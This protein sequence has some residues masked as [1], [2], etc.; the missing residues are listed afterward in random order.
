MNMHKSGLGMLRCALRSTLLWKCD[1]SIMKQVP[2]CYNI[3]SLA[4]TQLGS[5]KNKALASKSIRYYSHSAPDAA[6]ESTAA[7]ETT[8]VQQNEAEK[9][10]LL[11]YLA[12][13]KSPTEVLDELNRYSISVNEIGK[14]F[15][16]MWECIEEMNSEQKQMKFKLIIEHPEFSALCE[17]LMIEAG[18][19]KHHA[20]GRTLY[21]AVNLGVSQDSRVVQTLLRVAQEHLNQFDLNS[22]C[23]L[24]RVLHDMKSRNALALREA[25]WLLLKDHIYETSNVATLTKLMNVVG[26]DSPLKLK[27]QLAQHGKHRPEPHTSVGHL[28]QEIGRCCHKMKYRN[29]TLFSSISKHMALTIDMCT[30]QQVLKILQ[31]FEKLI[32]RPVELLDVFAERIIQEPEYL[33]VNELLTVLRVFSMANHDLKDKK[34]EFLSSLMPVIE[35]HL[36]KMSPGPL[37]SLAFY[38]S[39]MQHFPPKPLEILLQPRTVECLMQS[40]QNGPGYS[41]SEESHLNMNMHKSGLGM[42]RC[43]LRSTLLWKCDISIMKQV[44]LCYNIK[45][46]ASTQLGSDKN[47]ALASK[48][49]RYYSHSAP[50]AAKE[51]TAATETT[52]VQQ[53]E[54]EKNALLVYLAGCKSPT[55][56]LDELNR[57]SISVNEIG[58]IFFRMWE[59]IEEMNSEQ[60]QIKFKLIIEHPEFSALCERLMI[61]AGAMKHHA[62]GRTLYAAVNLGVSQDSRVVQTLLRV[63]QEHLNQF[64]LNSLC[65]LSRALHDMKS[66]NALALREAIWLLLKDHIYETSNVATLTKLMNVV[67]K[68]SPLKLKKQLASKVFSLSSEFTSVDNFYIFSSMANIDVKHTHLLDTCSKKLAENIHDYSFTQLL[69]VL[70]CCYQMKYRNYT[71]F[72]SISKHM[73]LTIDMC[74]DQQ[75]LKILQAFEKLIFRPVELLDVFAERIIQEPE[76]LSVNELLTVLRVFSMANHDLKDKKTE[77]LSSLM[78][79]IELHLPKMSPGPLLSLTFYLSLMQHFPPKPLEILLQPRTVECLMQSSQDGPEKNS[80]M[81]YALNLSLRLENPPLP[82]S[83]SSLTK[84]NLPSLDINHRVDQEIR[85]LIREIVGRDAV[86]EAVVEQGFY[87]IDFVIS[88]PVQEETPGLQTEGAGSSQCAQRIALITVRENGLCYGTNHYRGNVVRK[89]RHLEKLGYKT[90]LV[91]YNYF[92][93]MPEAEKIE[94]LRSI[95]QPQM[96][97]EIIGE[98]KTE[99]IS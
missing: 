37:L 97:K 67:G 66:R 70:R 81:L 86:Q 13:C 34:T 31:A 9:N 8:E 48:S 49:I 5:D 55:E 90:V 22:L 71:L 52:E 3:K 43:A 23:I 44:P 21:A 19:M 51:S 2:L 30:D 76:Y 28:Q 56:V 64:D 94:K 59:C 32:F 57:Y 63:A 89:A 65:I 24:S 1:I 42:L 72:S 96:Q 26:K 47:K 46:L 27:K 17:R 33:S 95:F 40:S 54:A 79:V 53:N 6:K 4:S 85:S 80:Y 93:L 11:V 10:A 77:F 16:R 75:V 88:L 14:I 82:S 45:S 62:L 78:P 50:D 15:F 99:G 36:P 61:E 18:A 58:K 87:F 25:I 7:T 69:K 35:L 68:D 60:K 39:L 12:G 83:M 91:P 20:L 38:L 73:A 98:P 41:R 84:L 74:T 29:Y 92:D